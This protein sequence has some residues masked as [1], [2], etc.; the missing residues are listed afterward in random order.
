MP[1]PSK[2]TTV[3]K[4]GTVTGKNVLNE[5]FL[6]K[7][8]NVGVQRHQG[9]TISLP[10]GMSISE[11]AHW[12]NTILKDEEKIVEVEEMLYGFPM[13]CA[14]AL[15]LAVEQ[16]FGVKEMRSTPGFFSYDPPSAANIAVNHKGETIT[17]YTGRFSVP[18]YAAETE[19]DRENNYIETYPASGSMEALVVK[20]RTKNRNIPLF[21]RLVAAAREQLLTHSIYRGKAFRLTTEDLKDRNGNV[22]KVNHPEFLDVENIPTDLLLND[23]T[24]Q[25][26]ENGIWT[27]IERTEQVRHYN[28]GNIRT[29]ALLYGAPGTGKS[30]TALATAK[31][32]QENGW[33]FI[34]CKDSRLLPNVYKLALR[35]APVVLFAEDIDM[36]VRLAGPDSVNMFNNILDG[37]D[38]KTADVIT[39]LTTNHIDVLPPVMLRPGRFDAV[40]HYDF[41]NANTAVRLVRSYLTN[42]IDETN[43]DEATVGQ[44]LQNNVPAV[45]H[46]VC[47]RA[48]KTAIRRYPKG[49]R[50][51][52]SITTQDIQISARGM[53]EHMNLLRDQHVEQE[54]PIVA[55]GKA[56]GAGVGNGVAAG[57]AAAQGAGAN[58][59]RVTRLPE[60]S[61]EM[62]QTMKEH[63]TPAVVNGVT[64]AL[65]AANAAGSGT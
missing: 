42:Q 47:K 24:Q 50:K 33:T 45:I 34:L 9:G 2:A 4:D 27:P 36:L 53:E 35:Y 38:S 17:V 16:M 56:F 44:V 18:E 49:Y 55:L 19:Y 46:E 41:P 32:A 3:S 39:I 25:L 52:L 65:K 57:M 20:T 14:H 21:N 63:A 10:E 12:L 60:I 15:Q 11:G 40:V 51:A 13:D 5:E 59:A 43:F 7:F 64:E 58:G 29:G 1:N 37:V 26:I 62:I 54:S 31:I 28:N 23:D 48:A 61:P 22:T 30:L 6:I 8:K